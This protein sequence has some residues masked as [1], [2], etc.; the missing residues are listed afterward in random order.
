M[1]VNQ[2]VVLPVQSTLEVREYELL[3]VPEKVVLF[4]VES[5]IEEY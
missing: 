5:P 2:H 1:L 4:A 3:A